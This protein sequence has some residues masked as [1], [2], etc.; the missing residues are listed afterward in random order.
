VQEDTG[1]SIL[2]KRY[3]KFHAVDLVLEAFGFDTIFLT[4]SVLATL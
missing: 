4:L 2:N 3:V 1:R